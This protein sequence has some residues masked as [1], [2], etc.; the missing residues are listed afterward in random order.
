MCRAFRVPVPPEV[1]PRGIVSLELK[2]E[3]VIEQRTNLNGIHTIN[4][5]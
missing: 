1:S 3:Y 2:R 5:T 4:L